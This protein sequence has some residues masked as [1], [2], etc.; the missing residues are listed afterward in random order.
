MF[1][2]VAEAANALS[3]VA[4]RPRTST[5]GPLDTDEFRADFEKYARLCFARYGDRVRKWV[6]FNEPYIISIFAH[7]NGTLAPGHCA[8]RG[9]DTKTD[10]PSVSTSAETTAAP[11]T[12]TATD[13]KPH[14]G[15]RGMHSAT[16]A[17]WDEKK[18]GMW[19][20]KYDGGEGKGMDVV[21]MLI[22][23]AI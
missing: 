3:S 16:G 6:T 17:Y 11:A 7:L 18:D 5:R 19:T 23:I 4:V 10:E 20:F 14:V 1:E 9:T 2:S 12:A 15:R 22:W 21:I 13:G 8:A